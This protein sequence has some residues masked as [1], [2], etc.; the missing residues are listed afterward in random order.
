LLLAA[1]LIICLAAIPSLR[2]DGNILNVL[3]GNSDAFL[4]YRKVQHEFRDFSGDLGII[5]RADD[6]YEPEGFE[7]LR[8]LPTM[9]SFGRR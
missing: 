5:V 9:R 2:F 7:R 6:L 1:S 8:E 4:N 3:S